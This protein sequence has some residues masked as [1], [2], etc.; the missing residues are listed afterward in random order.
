MT[1]LLPRLDGRSY[2]IQPAPLTR[3]LDEGDRIDTGD[4]S[5]TVLKPAGT[6]FGCIGL[7]DG[8]TGCCFRAAPSM[9]TA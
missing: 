7:Y 6:F 9:T 5:F 1:R 3:I 4:R 2:R 8:R